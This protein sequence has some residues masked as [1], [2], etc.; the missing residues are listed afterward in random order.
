MQSSR[1][2]KTCK[3]PTLSKTRDTLGYVQAFQVAL[4]KLKEQLPDDAMA[5]KLE[6]ELGG[7]VDP[8]A[9]ALA[10]I[11]RFV[12]LVA[13]VQSTSCKLGWWQGHTYACI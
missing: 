2:S 4:D 12:L 1:R 11:I 13:Q 3:P 8:I 6:A 9:G 10:S 5:S 7:C